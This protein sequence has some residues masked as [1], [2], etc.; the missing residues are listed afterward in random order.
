[1]N[2]RELLRHVTTTL[3]GLAVPYMLVGSFAGYAYG[4][5]R[6]THDI[7]LVLE[8]PMATVTPFC[9]AFPPPDFYLSEPAVRDAVRSRV[10]FNILHLTSGN[11]VDCVFP[12]SD[13]W[14]RTQLSRRRRQIILDDLEGYLASPED[15]II[16]KL[17]YYAEGGSEKHLRDIAGILRTSGELVDRSDVT[18]WAAKLGYQGI[19]ECVLKAVDDPN[20]PKV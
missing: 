2:Q 6:L 8:L 3:D 4:E 5:P 9:A 16:G 1:V 12:R 17:W 14:G 19:W 7:D 18:A 13:E 10:Q 15:V 11:K 20:S